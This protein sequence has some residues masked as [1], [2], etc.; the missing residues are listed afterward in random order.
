MKKLILFLSIFFITISGYSQYIFKNGKATAKM[1]TLIANGNAFIFQ[2]KTRTSTFYFRT[3]GDSCFIGDVNGERYIGSGSGGFTSG[4]FLKA[5]GVPYSNYAEAPNGALYYGN[6]N[7]S[8]GITVKDTNFIVR[9]SETP[10]LEV[11]YNYQQIGAGNT[12]FLNN[13]EN[14]TNGIYS[15]NTSFVA[16]QN[17]IIGDQIAEDKLN[18]TISNITKG[19]FVVT[20]TGGVS[21]QYY[22]DLIIDSSGIEYQK[23]NGQRIFKLDTLG[24]EVLKNGSDSIIL[25]PASGITYYKTGVK[26]FKIDTLGYI[27][28]TAPHAFSQFTDSSITLNLTQNT[29][30]QI[31]NPVGR[32]TWPV[33]EFYGFTD[34]SDTITCN[35]SGHYIVK[36]QINITGADNKMYEYRIM[37]RNGTTSEV[38]RYGVTGSGTLVLRDVSTYIDLYAGSKFWVEIRSTSSAPGSVNILGGQMRVYPIHLDL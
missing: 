24:M 15:D 26:K 36:Y 3:S 1:D 32:A 4:P 7:Y 21:Y 12:V 35:Y 27:H 25:N 17:I 38:W 19:R 22:K 10:L 14:G 6:G 31:T 33:T 13:I 28:N 37:R 2:N 5:P 20:C 23:S 8:Q 18:Q 9:I 29:W 11:S 16:S 30:Y 34:N